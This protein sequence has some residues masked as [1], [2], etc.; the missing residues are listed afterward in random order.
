MVLKL[1]GNLMSQPARALLLFLRTNNIP[2]EFQAVNLAKGEHYTEEYQ[3][4]NPLMKVPIIDDDGFVLRESVGILRYLCRERKVPDHWYP[5][6]SKAQAIVDQYLEWQH[7]DTRLNCA[8]FFMQKVS[9]FVG[10]L[11]YLCRE[12]DVPGHW[13]PKDSKRQAKVDEYLEWQHLDIRLNCSMFFVQKP[14]PTLLNLF[15][16]RMKTSL[17]LLEDVWLKDTPYLTGNTIT[18]ADLLGV[19]EVEQPRMGGYDPRTEYPKVAAWME[20]VRNELNPHYDD[21]HKLVNKIS[22]KAKL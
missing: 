4:L 3:K 6:E 5:K 9:K 1:Y 15:E 17:Q 22:A 8:T 2:H 19:C 21:V 11:R 10:I 12:R 13:Y 20:K 16:S 18:I 14:D 7:L